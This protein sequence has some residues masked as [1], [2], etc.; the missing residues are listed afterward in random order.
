MAK[1][2]K[3]V[4]VDDESSAR[5]FLRDMLAELP[6]VKIE[7]EAAGVDE[8]FGLVVRK[9]PDV[10]FLDVQM[11]GEDGFALVEKLVEKQIRV[12]I[13]FTTA[14]ERY[15]IRA[16]KAAAFDYL[17]KPVKRTE[18]AG[19]LVK[20]R[21]RIKGSGLNSRFSELIF[22]LSDKKKTKFPTHTGFVMIDAD[23]ILFCSADGADTLLELES[24]RN[25]RVSLRLEE[26]ENLLPEACFARISSS[27]VINLHYLAHVDRKLMTC[28]IINGTRHLLPV[29]KKYLKEIETKCHRHFLLHG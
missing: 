4:I 6:W 15:A 14:Y 19:S 7:G 10:I 28:E 24:G 1:I 20:L 11:S 29:S 5:S 27:L 22:Q 17:L 21:D 3:V 8:A 26:V 18:L 16:I 2:L 9:K 23:Q 12:E 13:I 25:T